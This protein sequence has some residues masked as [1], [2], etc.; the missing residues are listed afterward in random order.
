M[1][2]KRL[3]TPIVMIV[4]IILCTAARVFTISR[5][6]MSIGSIAH[7]SKI[8][9]NSLY[10]GVFAAAVAAAMIAVPSKRSAADDE[11]VPTRLD[12][13]GGGAAAMGFGLLAVGIGA[14]YDAIMYLKTGLTS[15][16]FMAISFCFAI[17]FIA[18]GFITLYKKEITPG[19]GFSFS[20][21]GVF[22]VLR[23]IFCFMNH[24]VVAAIPEYLIEVLGCV[25]GGLL[26][27]MAGKLFS[28]NEGRITRKM[29]CAW[30]VGAAVLTVS[31]LLGT[32][33]AKLFL[34]DEISQCIV[35]TSAKA[36]E[37][38]ESVNGVNGYRLAFPVFANM[39]LGIF[40]M[41]VVF[42]VCLSGK[43]KP[44]TVENCD[45]TEEAR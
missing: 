11:V 38:Y 16:I 33:A 22:F 45:N 10:F 36:A 19:L 27:A 35:L 43:E 37:Y 28:G 29:L 39:G 9:C 15:A 17:A 31:A 7:G 40:A 24:M 8:L 12:V 4:G 41:T 14:A 44:I 21:G 32:A 20:F 18:V 13:S 34:G 1:N 2:K 25:F 23:G 3:I 26:F 42:A 6:D 30:G 5:T